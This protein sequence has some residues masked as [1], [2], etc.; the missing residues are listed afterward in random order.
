MVIN[1]Y[2]PR[3]IEVL[4]EYDATYKIT[5]GILKGGEWI[6]ET[7]KEMRSFLAPDYTSAKQAAEKHRV[8]LKTRIPAGSSVKLDK[9]V[10]AESE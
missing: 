5:T 6:S 9:V 3:N 2:N 7:I 8:E 1:S 4:R 10:E